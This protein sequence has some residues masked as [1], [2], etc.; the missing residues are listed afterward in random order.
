MCHRRIFL[1]LFWFLTKST[2]WSSSCFHDDHHLISL[3]VLFLCSFCDGADFCVVFFSRTFAL[4]SSI[5]YQFIF[6]FDNCWDLQRIFF[7]LNR[8]YV[9]K[10]TFVVS[11]G[12]CRLLIHNGIFRLVAQVNLFRKYVIFFFMRLACTDFYLHFLCVFVVYRSKT[13][14]LESEVLNWFY[15]CRMIFLF[16]KINL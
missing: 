4:H 14:K 6:L 12:G 5:N 11:G 16:W 13:L 8:F 10:M 3:I 9:W 15:W 7:H 2:L 1:S